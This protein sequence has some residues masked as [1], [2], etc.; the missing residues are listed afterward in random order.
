MSALVLRAA[1]RPG[2]L[3]RDARATLWS[4]GQHRAEADPSWVALR[5]CLPACLVGA[6]SLP[7][8]RRRSWATE[9]ELAC[10]G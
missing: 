10:W 7:R 9:A 2:D 6:T 1:Q 5:S 3:L 8:P 4:K